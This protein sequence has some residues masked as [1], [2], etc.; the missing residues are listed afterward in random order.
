MLQPDVALVGGI[1]GLRRVAHHGAGARLSSSR[2]T[3]GPTAWASTANAHL[4]AGLADSPFLEFPFDPP[5]WSLERRDFMM[6]EP[7]SVGADGTIN[8]SDAPGMGYALNE[9]L[10]AKTLVKQVRE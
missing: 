9:S 4:A 2:R 6:A 7:L 1:T 8:L 3:P 10:L 5:E